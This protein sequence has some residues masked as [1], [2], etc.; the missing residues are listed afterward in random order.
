MLKQFDTWIELIYL[1]YLFYFVLRTIKTLK[2]NQEEVVQGTAKVIT[3][4]LK[5]RCALSD[6]A[7]KQGI[8]MYITDKW[9]LIKINIFRPFYWKLVLIMRMDEEVLIILIL[10]LW[11][12]RINFDWRPRA[13]MLIKWKSLQHRARLLSR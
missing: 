10:S 5:K 8:Q 3:T 2:K 11:F 9:N 12:S 7:R 13:K 1:F 4:V 6:P